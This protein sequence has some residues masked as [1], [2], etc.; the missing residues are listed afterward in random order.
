MPPTLLEIPFD[1]YQRYAAAA[2][3]LGTLDLEQPK[4]L[5]V[6]AN[7]QRLLGRFLPSAS[8]LYTDLHAEGD[9]TDFIVADATD[10][11]FP[12][13]SFDVVVSLDVLEH[14]PAPLR[15]RAIAEM[16]RVSR[17]AV[18]LG[19]PPDKPWV[20]EAE[21]NA[22]N[23]WF[24][25]F[26]GDYVWLEEHK[27]F[28]LVNT[29]E[30][31]ATLVNAG[32]E[33]LCFGQG[34]AKLWAGLM[35]AHFIKVK[36]PE[37]EPLVAAADRLYNSR[38]F[39]G[40]HSDEPYREYYVGLRDHRD[41]VHVQANSPF[42]SEADSEAVLLLAGLADGLRQLALR[43]CNSEKEW[44]STARLLD[45]HRVD[46]ETAKR[47]WQE[48]AAY[49]L[50]LQVLKDSSDADWLA[51]QMPVVAELEECRAEL[52]RISGEVDCL[53]SQKQEAA[54][55]AH[56]LSAELEV[57]AERLHALSV[58]WQQEQEHLAHELQQK[59]DLY[60]RSLE[61]LQALKREVDQLR[62]E[63]GASMSQL[64]VTESQVHDARLHAEQVA[65]E[66]SA[67]RAAEQ[68]LGIA[69]EAAKLDLSAAELKFS[70]S[71]AQFSRE[72]EMLKQ[73]IEANSVAYA[74]SRRKWT[75]ALNVFAIAAT[76]MGSVL[77]WGTL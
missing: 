26:G 14:I 10:L 23:R 31:E 70:Q 74:K 69:L 37:L 5:E 76:I 12:D 66:L 15:T 38:I 2:E 58:E 47:N 39:A 68:D 77:V 3:L 62:A 52:V 20:H 41:V 22:N 29:V 64:A 32:M 55:L 17:R 54:E 16:S 51:H 72:Q 21:I 46:L 35:G 33:V 24:E 61:E 49:A 53:T 9:E 13:Q 71:E 59:N 42:Q 50:Q 36:F 40:D 43:T 56:S 25:L 73:R 75:L 48:T 45:A 63:L 57:N 60:A 44:E 1:H 65:S 18:I 4:V 27:E 30:V 28:G 6:G 7:R 34:N 67:S 19:F 11:P 8:L